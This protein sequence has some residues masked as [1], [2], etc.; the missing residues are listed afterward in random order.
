MPKFFRSVSGRE[1]V[2]LLGRVGFFEVSQKG[3]H[4]K[5]KD[6]SGS[7]IIIIPDHRELT[8][9]TFRSILKMANITVEDFD[10]LKQ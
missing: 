10:H 7:K 9:G 8:S 3:S 6:Q 1:M 2:K 5:L 4:I